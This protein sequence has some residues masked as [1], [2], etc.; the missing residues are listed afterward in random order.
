MLTEPHHH[1]RSH[2][3]EQQPDR[4]ER[5]ACNTNGR[6][7]LPCDRR[8]EQSAGIAGDRLKCCDE[9]RVHGCELCGAYEHGRVGPVIQRGRVV[10]PLQ[11]L[12]HTQTT[13]CFRGGIGTRQAGVHNL[14]ELQ[15]Q[16]TSTR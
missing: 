7:Q 16:D 10:Y 12:H 9:R 11:A 4:G 6:A 5:D 14:R 2:D 3:G 13:H 8:L 1:H 15:R